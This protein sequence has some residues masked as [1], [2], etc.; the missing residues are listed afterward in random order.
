LANQTSLTK[1]DQAHTWNTKMI[2]AKGK[3]QNNSFSVAP[4]NSMTERD[5][6]V[7]KNLNPGPGSYATEKTKLVQNPNDKVQNSFA[8]KIDRFCP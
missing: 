2:T 5:K 4:F 1:L 6:T 7:F 3:A 8:T